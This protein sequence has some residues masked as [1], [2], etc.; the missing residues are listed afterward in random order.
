MPVITT[1]IIPTVKALTQANQPSNDGLDTSTLWIIIVVICTVLVFGILC[2]GIRTENR[3]MN[4]HRAENRR[5]VFRTE[6]IDLSG[7]RKT[8]V[9]NNIDELDNSDI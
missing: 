5:V 3:D 9:N 8:V 4:H 7:R 6:P 2:Y 1:T